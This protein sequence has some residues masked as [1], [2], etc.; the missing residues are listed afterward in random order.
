MSRSPHLAPLAPEGWKRDH[1]PQPSACIG[2]PDEPELSVS[3]R[4]S[5][6]AW[7][8]R[9]LAPHRDTPKFPNSSRRP[10]RPTASATVPPL[11]TPVRAAGPAFLV[12]GG[13]RFGHPAQRQAIVVAIIRG[14][15][16]GGCGTAIETS[17]FPAG[18][19]CPGASHPGATRD[20]LPRIAILPPA[21]RRMINMSPGCAFCGPDSMLWLPRSSRRAPAV[22]QEHLVGAA[23]DRHRTKGCLSE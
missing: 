6:A 23:G 12:V 10:S 14:T 1:Q 21:A 13:L 17:C 5:R 8:R 4:Q 15:R 20:G 19:R 3:A 18:G 16:G 7:A 2:L 22:G 9:L 11:A